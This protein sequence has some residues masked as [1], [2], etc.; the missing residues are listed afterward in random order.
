M[1]IRFSFDLSLLNYPLI[2]F[3]FFLNETATVYVIYFRARSDPLHIK[4]NIKNI[5]IKKLLFFI[6]SKN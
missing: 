2:L 6:V 1:Q 4:V 3:C 5:A